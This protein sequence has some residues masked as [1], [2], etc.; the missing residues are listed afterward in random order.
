MGINSAFNPLKAELYPVCHL[1]ALLGAHHIIH[2]SRIRV[3]AH[4]N[5]LNAEVNPIAVCWHYYELT[6]LSTLAG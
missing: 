4:F 1:L 2:V 5:P 6:I 3:K